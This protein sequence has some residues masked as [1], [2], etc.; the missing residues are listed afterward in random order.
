M[1][2]I[3]FSAAAANRF[4][5]QSALD[6][7]IDRFDRDAPRFAVCN[8]PTRACIFGC[9]DAQS[10]ARCVDYYR[11]CSSRVRAS[12]SDLI[13]GAASRTIGNIVTQAINQDTS[14]CQKKLPVVSDGKLAMPAATKHVSPD[15]MTAKTKW[16]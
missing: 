16:L 3:A 13:A 1:V 2:S 10:G 15:W 11:V 14:Q 12:A 5:C 9:A 6:V 8:S 4:C 7:F